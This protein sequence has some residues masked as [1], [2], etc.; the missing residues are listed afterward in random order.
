MHDTGLRLRHTARRCET[1]AHSR[2]KRVLLLGSLR[3]ECRTGGRGSPGRY[4]GIRD[5]YDWLRW[6]TAW[7]TLMIDHFF[8]T[9]VFKKDVLVW[10]EF[11]GRL[12]KLICDVECRG[13][14]SAILY[15]GVSIW[16]HANAQ[17]KNSCTAHGE[18]QIGSHYD[19]VL[20][21]CHSDFHCA[22]IEGKHER[23]RTSAGLTGSQMESAGGTHECF[24]PTTQR[25]ICRMVPCLDCGV[26]HQNRTTIRHFKSA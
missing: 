20:Q 8:E 18:P 10:S 11:V 15:A 21:R 22:A 7:R 23:G 14:I 26:A 12:P 5:R 4:T 6:T 3:R 16:S 1:C 2:R 17:I 24:S 13:F 9:A 19:V 25:Y